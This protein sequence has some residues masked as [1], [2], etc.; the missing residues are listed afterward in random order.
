[1]P[2]TNLHTGSQV[3]SSLVQGRVIW[4]NSN[5]ADRNDS[6]LEFPNLI[7]FG[8][9]WY[10][11]FRESPIHNNHPDGRVRIIRSQDAEHWETATLLDWDCADVR[12]VNLAITAE[13][14][15]MASSSVYFVSRQP[16]A[17]VKAQSDQGEKSYTPPEARKASDHPDAYY[18]LD[19]LGTTLN[20]PDHDEEA[21]VTQQSVTWITRDGV[22]WSSAYACDTGINSWRWGLRWHDGM[23][24]SVAQW[25]KD[26]KGTLYRTRD[27]K[28]WRVLTRD[29]FPQ[30]HGGETALAFDEQGAIG[31]LRGNNRSKVFLGR[32]AGPYFQQWHWQV[33]LVDWN[34]DGNARPASEVLGVGMGGPALL[35]LTDSRLIAA[36][37]VLGPDADD[38]RVTVFAVDVKN[39]LLTRILTCDGTSYPGICEYD[40]KLW[41]SYVGSG[42]T[43]G[44]WEIRLAQVNLTDL[45]SM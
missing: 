4:D 39:N 41:I 34:G 2:P 10:C 43:K 31:L 3:K 27:G 38:G 36:G 8:D 26:V 18:Q 33:P 24:Y 6:R 12:E 19:W 22:N 9:Y 5:I 37:R 11:A 14:C 21:L 17:R 45:C 29:V 32:A 7:R 42:C 23:C 44:H 25:G 16:R 15:L 28:S 20:L 1:M 30:E 40:G 35:K 13:G